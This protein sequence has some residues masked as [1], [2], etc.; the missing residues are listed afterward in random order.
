MKAFVAA[1]AT[2]V[3]YFALSAIVGPVGMESYQQLSAYRDR[4][5]ENVAALESRGAE[6]DAEAAAYRSDAGRIA[7]EARS[8]GYFAPQEGLVRVDGFTPERRSVAAGRLLERRPT[9]PDRLPLIRWLSLGFGVT[10]YLVLRLVPPKIRT[11]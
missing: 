6:L 8:I 4:L 11:S 5:S 10:V 1:S 7:V 3:L 2:C 9:Q